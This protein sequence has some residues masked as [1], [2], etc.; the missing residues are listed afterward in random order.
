MHQDNTLK[1]LKPG[2]P[3]DLDMLQGHFRSGFM[4]YLKQI[5]LF[6]RDYLQI[7]EIH[8]PANEN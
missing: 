6:G 8:I 5:D 1:E 3:D 7:T 4:P 2:P